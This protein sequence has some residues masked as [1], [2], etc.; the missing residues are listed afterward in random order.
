[1]NM[2]PVL[3]L[4]LGSIDVGTKVRLKEK[5]PYYLGLPGHALTIGRE[6]T[7]TVTKIKEDDESQVI[8]TG[9]AGVSVEWEIV[10]GLTL[11]GIFR[12]DMLEVVK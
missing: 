4:I 10:P 11:S 2:S 8:A 7:G 6:L 5:T 12:S 1:M 9:V 3:R